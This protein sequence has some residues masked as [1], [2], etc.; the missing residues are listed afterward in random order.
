MSRAEARDVPVDR[1]RARLFIEAADE[2][3][4]DAQQAGTSL[5]GSA[6]LYY[7][8]CVSAMKAVLAAA[9]RDVGGGDAGH[10]VM[11]GETNGILGDAYTDLL[12]RVSEDRRERNDVSYAAVRAT[13]LAVEAMRSDARELIDAARVFVG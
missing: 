1:D 8:T 5:N 3:Y 13:P 6:I 11:I 10:V 7:Q 4:A 2:F 9:G 12:T